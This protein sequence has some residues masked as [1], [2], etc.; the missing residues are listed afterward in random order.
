MPIVIKDA[1]DI[2]EERTT[3]GYEGFV[4]EAGGID[5]IPELDAPIVSKLEE[6]GAVILGKTNLPAF[7]ADGTRANSSYF[8]P[9]FNAYDLTLA[10]GASS[11][12][13]ATAVSASFAVMG[14]AEET[15]GSIQNPAGAQALVGIKPTFGLVP[16]T[17]VIP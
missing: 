15:G 1:V 11:S 8:G 14:I 9:T 12:G 7:S 4:S 3:G 2:A 10:P 16:N 5:L 13:S 6:A 17:G